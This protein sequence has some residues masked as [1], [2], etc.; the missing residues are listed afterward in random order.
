[1]SAAAQSATRPPRTR[2]G[3]RAVEGSTSW[4][5]TATGRTSRS[6]RSGSAVKT[7]VTTAPR[8]SPS[9]TAPPEIPP[10]T[11]SPGTIP[12]KSSGSRRC[13]AAPRRTPS[14]V[15]AAASS[16]TMRAACRATKPEVAPSARS[17][18]RVSRFSRS[19]AVSA[20]WM[21]KPASTSV[22]MPISE[23]KKRK[24][25][26]KRFT[27]V[28]AVRKVSTRSSPASASASRRAA[29]VST[30]SSRAAF[31]SVRRSTRLPA[32]TSPSEARSSAWTM[33]RGPKEKALSGR[34]GSRTSTS[35]TASERSPSRMASPTRSPRRSSSACSAT[36][37]PGA[38]TAANGRP[39]PRSTVP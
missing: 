2:R 14:A 12:A 27:P 23:R 32:C 15:P 36:T 16:R 31:R 6:R 17:T 11:A 38:C 22:K 30:R 26:K 9:S 13:A 33:T 29:S 21:P 4:P 7:P 39:E 1:M 35:R 19:S 28:R 24:L 18:A 37:P 25:S 20:L 3:A 5:R 8:S 34:S 10:E